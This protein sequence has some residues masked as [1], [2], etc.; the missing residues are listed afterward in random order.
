MMICVQLYERRKL[1]PADVLY[2]ITACSERTSRLQMGQVGRQAGELIQ[3]ALFVGRIGHRSQQTLLLRF[4]RRGKQ[5]RG[6][7]F[8]EDLS[9]EDYDVMIGHDC[10]DAEI[11]SNENNARARLAF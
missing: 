11:L 5:V 1:T 3:L 8:L 7:D 2:V 9:G 4:S 10:D 6:T